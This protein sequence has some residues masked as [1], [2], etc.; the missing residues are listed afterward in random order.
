MSAS[1]WVI[2]V[3][4]LWHLTALV[5]T[6]VPA[7]NRLPAQSPVDQVVANPVAGRFAP[8]L[9][10]AAGWLPGVSS[11]IRRFVGP[12]ER[13]ASIYM[14][15][16]GL[17]QDWRMFSN[18]PLTDEYMRLRYYV[19]TGRSTNASWSAL[20]LVEPA[21]RE[22]QVRLL[23]SYRDSYLD[24]ALAVALQNFQE[25][26]RQRSVGTHAHPP[27]PPDD[28]T[29]IARYFARRFARSNLV[30]G[31]RV[32]RTEVWYG[33]APNPPPGKELSPEERGLRLAVLRDYYAGPVQERGAISAYPSFGATEHEADITWVLAYTE[34]R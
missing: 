18:P 32:V 13:P 19:G 15:A 5:I 1:R 33:W 17:A 7:P 6:A 9:S 16:L 24:K 27:H 25:H 14:T 26:A 3:F 12:I 22:D 30:A 34:Q 23:Q 29:P 20:E 28:L 2:S 21:Q 4:L 8:V 31:E 11:L 10:R